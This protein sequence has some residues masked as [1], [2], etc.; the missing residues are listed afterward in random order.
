MTEAMADDSVPARSER[1]FVTEFL[2]HLSL[3]RRLS[4][5]T[6]RNYRHAL[7][8][9]F[10]YLRQSGRW[11]GDLDK[12]PPLTLRSYI[13]DAQRTGISR[14]TLHLRISAGRS[15]FRYLLQRRAVSAS[16]FTGLSVPAF[17]KPLPKFLTERQMVLF[18]EG[19]RRRLE[20]GAIEPWEA[21]RDLLVFELLYG[22]GLRVSELVDLRHGRIDRQ[23]G[24]ARIVGKGR[25]ER[26]CP[27]GKGALAAL[28]RFR[29]DF[30]VATGPEDPVLVKSGG[31]PVTAGWVQR[32]MKIY[33]REA[34]LPLDLTPHKLRH[35]FAT[36]LLN[37][38][39]DLRIVQELLGH[40]S[41]GTTQVYTHVSLQRLKDVHRRAHPRG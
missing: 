37:A 34:E 23:N 6:V 39:A 10:S 27:L 19:P 5:Y 29:R 26:L 20:A 30:A 18:L 35:S 14:R 13:I 24:L 11:G 9:L 2:A 41:L 31:G 36:H 3:E 17:R 16:P 28:E 7:D 4:P 12:I 21:C 32:R 25:K 38:G 1:D 22:A 40:A 8:D 33:L 15:F